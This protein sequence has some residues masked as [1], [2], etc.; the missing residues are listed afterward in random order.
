[1]LRKHFIHTVAVLLV[2][3]SAYGQQ[4][5]ERDY[6]VNLENEAVRSYMKEVVYEPGD[7]SLIDNYKI[8]VKHI[9]DWPLPVV[10]DIPTVNA[11]SVL[12]ECVN[13]EIMPEEFYHFKAPTDN[14][15]YE[16]FNLTPNRIY[17]YRIIDNEH[18]LQ[19]G[20]IYTEGQ[21]R[22]IKIPRE[23]CNI[24][25]MGGWKTV[26]NQRMKYG[27]IIRG[28]EL[29][30]ELSTT[31]E[32]INILRSLGISSELDM[33]AWYNNN[34]NNTSAFGFQD[35]KTTPADEVPTYYYTNNSGQLPEHM[36]VFNWQYRWRKEFQFIVANLREG[37]T[38]YQH[39]VNGRDRTGYL[40]VLLEGILGVSYSDIIKDFELTYFAFNLKSKKDSID[41]VFNYIEKLRG[42]TLRDKFETYFLYELSVSASD[43]E[44]FRSEMLEPDTSD[45][46]N[47]VIHHVGKS[48]NEKPSDCLYDLAGRRLSAIGDRQLYI[49]RDKDGNVRKML[50][51]RSYR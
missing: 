25:D 14:N 49:T 43:I 30:G 50:R 21:V 24:R 6:H 5:I 4:V 22:M 45:E 28:S 23:S 2:S 20:K 48:R 44:Y 33:R 32:G 12:I 3:L 27:K 38:I 34:G 42:T 18:V 40:S 16:I 15:T 10:V 11:D 26:D 35:E 8:N 51:Q 9:G 1:M 29:N 19:Q 36:S 41:K 31:E 47:V 13:N 7:T 46:T 37:R 17:Q 39:C